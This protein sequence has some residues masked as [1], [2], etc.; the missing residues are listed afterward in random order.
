M[1]HVPTN[2]PQL[3]RDL[4]SKALLQTDAVQLERRRANRRQ[5]LE[6]RTQQQKIDDKLRDVDVRLTQYEHLLV[7]LIDQVSAL[8]ERPAR[9]VSSSDR[10]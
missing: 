4:N 9:D 2:Q 5:A 10:E 3:L 7:R 6:V 8:V 1:S